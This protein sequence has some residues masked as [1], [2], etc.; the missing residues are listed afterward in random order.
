M[1]D[2]KNLEQA[3]ED[4]E[5]AR[6]RLEVMLESNE[7]WRVL[8]IA[9][10]KQGRSKTKTRADGPGK[11]QLRRKL[12]AESPVYRAYQRLIDALRLLRQVAAVN[13]GEGLS[14]RQHS[15]APRDGI[16]KRSPNSQ[17]KPRIKIKAVS[18]SFP[19]STASAASS[20]IANSRTLSEMLSDAGFCL[21]DES[22]KQLPD[23]DVSESASTRDRPALPYA[24]AVELPELS[25]EEAEVSFVYPNADGSTLSG[26]SDAR[27]VALSTRLK[28]AADGEN[29]DGGRYT[30]FHGTTEEAEV[31]IFK[32]SDEL[33][34]TTRRP[35]P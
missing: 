1:S 9:E 4:L 23:P 5:R 8:T 12:L 17:A 35:G 6:K 34:G 18:R 15:A 16:R 31:E 3:L 19:A 2:G 10:M 26:S 25:V 20:P 29:A 11:R 7:A 22:M 33:A 28:H 13:D 14:A 27:P 30:P 24:D 21:P 32:P